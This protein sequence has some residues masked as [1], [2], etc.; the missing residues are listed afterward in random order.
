LALI[1]S[2]PVF[3]TTL[4]R[5]RLTQLRRAYPG[6][7]VVLLAI[8]IIAIPIVVEKLVVSDSNMRYYLS[9]AFLLAVVGWHQRRPDL[10]FVRKH[11]AQPNGSLM[12][13]YL[14]LALPVMIGFGMA[15]AWV[16]VGAVLFGMI[17][18]V[19][20]PV[21]DPVGTHM[22]WLRSRIPALLFEMKAGLQR[23]YPFAFV[24]W[25]LALA[26]C[27]L[28]ALPLFLTWVLTMIMASQFEECESRAMLL[29]TA[30]DARS[31]LNKKI[32]GSL[33]IMLLIMA[34]V[35]IAATIARPEWW[36]IHG[37]FGLG[38]LS[39]IALAVIL[40]YKEYIP[41]ERLTAN[42]ATIAIGAV[43]ALL[44][45]LFLLPLL[46]SLTDRRKA[47]ENLDLYFHA[48]DH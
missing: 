32:A 37:L 47:L 8:A 14:L 48:T 23:T 45:G 25:V 17:A 21:M 1:V 24:I 30:S 12:L 39:V 4:V 22:R 18:L 2:V 26:F 11:I 10:R 35:L 44:P 38:Q 41:N 33:K 20:M 15:N 9:G 16:E 42:G 3:P 43:F 29:V 46:M 7:W 13:E 5:L 34:P 36:W 40:K 27:W 28:P 6:W 31:I 19:F